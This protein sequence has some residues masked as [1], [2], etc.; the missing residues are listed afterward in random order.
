MVVQPLL[1][2]EHFLAVGR[3]EFHCAGVACKFQADVGQVVDRNEILDCSF[4]HD[5]PSREWKLSHVGDLRLVSE[6]PVT[7]A[8]ERVS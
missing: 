1:G 8:V 4:H 7:F 2:S 5:A 3:V 6:T